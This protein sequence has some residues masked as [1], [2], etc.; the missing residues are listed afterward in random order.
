MSEPNIDV[1][2]IFN[3]D[4]E[5]VFVEAR[6]MKAD[7]S[8]ASRVM[9]HP[10]ENGSSIADHRVIEPN[11][12]TLLMFLP[13]D[14]FRDLYAQ[15]A[16]AFVTAQKFTVQTKVGS[17]P[18]MFISEMPHEETPEFVDLVQVLVK[19]TEVTFLTM[20]FEAAPVRPAPNKSASKSTVKRGEQA[21]K[22]DPPTEK[23]SSVAYGWFNK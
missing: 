4:F 15:L 7:V 22:A 16:T 8:R 19:L 17:F 6:A 23:K 3:E 2:G 9:R 13:N 20:Q 11:E 10:L 12:I 21:P 18:D 14:L 5:Q 1:T